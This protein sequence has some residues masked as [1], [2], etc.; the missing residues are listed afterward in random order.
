[1]PTAAAPQHSHSKEVY[2]D[3]IRLTERMHRQ[4]LDVIRAELDRLKIEDINSVQCLILFNIGPNDLSVGEL[5]HRGYYLGSNVSYNV[6]KMVANGYM[7]QERSVHDRRSF[8]VRLTSR[9]LELWRQIDQMFDAQVA[10]LV[11]TQ[12]LEEIQG[13]SGVYRRLEQFW[14]TELK[15][16]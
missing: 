9:G 6:R 11:E 5:T 7:A 2:L 4:F 1:M 16:L 15:S 8:H 10:A 12:K 13:A 14:Q 3:A